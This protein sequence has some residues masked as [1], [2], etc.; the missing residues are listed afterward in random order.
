MRSSLYR[1]Y[2]RWRRRWAAASVLGARRSVAAGAV[3]DDAADLPTTARAFQLWA[4]AT[5]QTRALLKAR[6]LLTLRLR[7]RRLHRGLRAWRGEA[8]EAHAADRGRGAAL[9]RAARIGMAA[10]QRAALRA[11][12]E[13]AVR[14]GSV[15]N[16]EAREERARLARLAERAHAA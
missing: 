8:R 7:C 14:L 2:R 16:F 13:E 3:D 6:S 15:R 11:W 4:A 1:S 9:L 12:R 5:R 10:Q